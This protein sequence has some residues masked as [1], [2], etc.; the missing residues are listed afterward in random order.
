M[1]TPVDLCNRSLTEMGARTIINSL[2]ENSAA[3]VACKVFYNE[4]VEWL[5]RVAP[6][7]FARRTINLTQLAVQDPT[8]TTPNSFYPWL[9]K[10][11]YPADCVKFRYVLPPPFPPGSTGSAPNV[12][13]GPIAPWCAPSRAWRFL[14]A[15]D[16]TDDDPP[17]QR[18]VLLSNVLNAVGVYTALVPNPDLMDKGF[19]D[20]LVAT[21]AHKLIL[22]LAGNVQ[23]KTQFYQLAQARI[24]EAR[25][26]DGNEAI[27]TSDI[28]VDWMAA[29]GV[30]PLFGLG[31]VSYGEWASLGYWY[32][33]YDS[34]EW[35]M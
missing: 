27:P 17:Q 12:S 25:V 28:P 4:T 6:W 21:L 9:V 13:S 34:A 32:S 7:G 5:L 24:M 3:A 22:P 26:Q 10:Y 23:M 35:G 18:K 14:P 15:T 33:G 16:F 2:D 8:V 11:A 19:K 30:T 31:P 20:A 29:R 1:T